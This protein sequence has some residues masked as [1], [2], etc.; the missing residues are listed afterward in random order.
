MSSFQ[1]DLQL[2]RT[3]RKPGWTESRKTHT[4]KGASRE[5]PIEPLALLNVL[6]SAIEDVYLARGI[7][8]GAR[9]YNSQLGPGVVITCSLFSPYFFSFVPDEPGNDEGEDGEPEIVPKLRYYDPENMDE[10]N[11]G[12]PNRNHGTWTFER[13]STDAERLR[14][15]LTGDQSAEL[16]KFCRSASTWQIGEAIRLLIRDLREKVKPGRTK[17]DLE[18][19]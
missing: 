17:I 14:L 16:S 15:S 10:Y 1:F 11:W 13:M 19:E 6:N 5:V 12:I 7:Y 4:L 3:R 8:P 18:N 9:L 2:E